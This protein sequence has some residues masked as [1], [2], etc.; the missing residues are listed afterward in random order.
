MVAR[1]MPKCAGSACPV[2]EYS[3]QRRHR[4]PWKI[5][6]DSGRGTAAKAFWRRP[7]G[8]LAGSGPMA[9]YSWLIPHAR[10]FA[11]ADFTPHRHPL[12]PAPAPLFAAAKIMHGD[13]AQKRGVQVSRMARTCPSATTSSSLTRSDLSLPEAG[14]ATGISIFMAS[15]NTMSSPSPTLPPTSTGSAQTRPATSVTILISGIPLSGTAPR[16]WYTEY[17]HRE[18]G[19]PQLAVVA[20]DCLR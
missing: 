9:G 18:G 10:G 19:R 14:A 7:S 11:R 2:P 12:K 6:D 16:D 13:F 8:W 17:A 5:P 4:F 20:A 3:R 15:T 1:L